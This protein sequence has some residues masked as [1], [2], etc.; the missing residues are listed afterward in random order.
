M[1]A[2]RYVIV[3]VF[4]EVPFCGNQLA[5]FTDAREIPEEFLQ[6]LA[7]E[8]NFSE[9][10]FVYPPDAGGHAKLRIF[11]PVKEISFAGHPVLGAAF[12]LA[13]PLQLEQIVLE[14][15][16]EKIPVT[17]DREGPRII[18]GW[19]EQ[20]VPKFKS[21]ADSASLLEA[22]G[23]SDSIL[24]VDLYD[25]GIQ[26][27]MVNVSDAKAVQAIDPDM[28]LL[29]QLPHAGT[30]CF[31]GSGTDF[32]TR[33]FAP[34]L[35]VFEDPA[36][37][38]AA[39]SLAAHLMRYGVVPSG[40]EITMHQ[41]GCIARPSILKAVAYGDSNSIQQVVVGGSAVIVSRGEFRFQ[42]FDL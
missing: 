26:H 12:V 36:T 20:P 41:G 10:V 30:S 22:L 34:K 27:V 6:Q 24:P 38:S 19:M 2:I 40:S 8:F 3:D 28:E 14:T 5:V 23:L 1:L 18:F 17:V 16:E 13:G 32:V 21:F 42:P 11:T 9:T 4:T 37:G 35:G 33:V 25:N 7:R 29:S 31:A 39:G 15:K